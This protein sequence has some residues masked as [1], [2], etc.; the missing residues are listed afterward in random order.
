MTTQS[1]TR[2]QRRQRKPWPQIRRVKYKGGRDAWMMDGRSNGK[3]E[4]L[5]FDTKQ[6]AEAKR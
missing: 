1:S 2:G 4:R 3:G 6:E 5:F